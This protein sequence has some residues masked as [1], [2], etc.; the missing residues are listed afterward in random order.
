MDLLRIGDTK[1]KVTLTEEDM[2]KY[3][4]DRETMDYDT[5][6]TR[7]ALWQILDEAKHSTGFD[8]GGERLF[9]QVYPSRGGGCELYVTLLSREDEEEREEEA[10]VRGGVQSL[11]R[12]ESLSHLLAACRLLHGLG[13]IGESAAYTE[14]GA[15]F[16]TVSQSLVGDL[17]E[18]SFL[19]EY[20]TRT[21]CGARLAYLSEHGRCLEGHAAVETLA[22]L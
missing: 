7:S 9:V 8:A 20:G 15:Y 21:P 13:Y 14:G 12:F 6:E 19:E 17:P 1:L 3:R 16:L 10:T 5:T 18:Y 11:Y 2:E 22:P 4:L